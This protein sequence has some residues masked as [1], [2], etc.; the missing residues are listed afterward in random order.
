MN[1]LSIMKVKILCSLNG[2]MNLPI[3]LSMQ[4]NLIKH[5]SY[6]YLFLKP[7]QT[8]TTQV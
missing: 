6:W 7:H 8:I 5:M 1:I 3:M 4:S 2:H